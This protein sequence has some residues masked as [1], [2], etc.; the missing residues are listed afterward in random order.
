MILGMEQ[1]GACEAANMQYGI[2]PENL[3]G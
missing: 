1:Q 3:R 2:N